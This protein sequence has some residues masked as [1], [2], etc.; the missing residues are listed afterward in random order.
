V[1]LAG[2][3]FRRAFN[4]I[5]DRRPLYFVYSVDNIEVGSVRA[6]GVRAVAFTRRED[7]TY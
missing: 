5:G 3:E 4:V 7:A 6:R 2:E 1:G